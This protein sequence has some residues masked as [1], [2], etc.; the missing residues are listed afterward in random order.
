Y[1]GRYEDELIS[2]TLHRYKQD[3]DY[4]WPLLFP[5]VK[6]AVNAMDAVQEFSA[7]RLAT[8]IAEFIVSGFSKR[9][10]TTWLT[11]AV[12]E[13]VAAIA[14]MVID[15]LN[16]PVSLQYQIET[17]G[18]YSVQIQDYVRLGIPQSATTTDGREI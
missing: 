1:G 5:M 6:S 12:D 18:D 14:P 2:M 17:W 7:G 9:G 10:W 13:R 4:E 15:I 11:A 16:M 3:N 8:P